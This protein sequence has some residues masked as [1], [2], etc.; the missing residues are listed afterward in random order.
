MSVPFIEGVKTTETGD[1][2]HRLTGQE[3]G[4]VDSAGSILS[5]P[6][7]SEEVARQIKTATDPLTEQLE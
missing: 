4:E 6:V 5:T 3:P 7:T 2:T 1:E